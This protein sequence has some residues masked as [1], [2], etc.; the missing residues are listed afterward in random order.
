MTEISNDTA[1]LYLGYES[2]GLNFGT[3]CIK[4][5]N[6]AGVKCQNT[7]EKARKEK[8]RSG[9][10][11]EGRFRSSLV[12]GDEYFLTCLRYIELNPV[13]AGIVKNPGDSV[14]EGEVIMILEA[15]KM[16]LPVVSPAAGTV[17]EVKC[18]NGDTVEADAVLITLD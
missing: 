12:Q 1:S 4:A 13:R 15:M 6:R 5:R 17:K 3:G 9:T 11:Y 7:Q 16:E 2:N 8:A 10:W 14:A 18:S